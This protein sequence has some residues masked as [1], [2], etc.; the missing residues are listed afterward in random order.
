M[1][2]EREGKMSSTV[3]DVVRGKLKTLMV[4]NVH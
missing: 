2:R 4:R 1:I 3:A